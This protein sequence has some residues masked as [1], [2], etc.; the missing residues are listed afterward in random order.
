VQSIW[1]WI[2]SLEFGGISGPPAFGLLLVGIVIVAALVVAF[3]IFGLPRLNRRSTVTGVLFGE[4][5]D[6]DAAAMR[7]AADAAASA[8]DYPVAI[9][10]M[11]R[12]IAKAMVERTIV[13]TMPGTTAQEFALRAG[14]AFPAFADLLH[15]AAVAFDDVRYLSGAGSAE[16]FDRISVLERELRTARPALEPALA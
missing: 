15:E 3:L 4:N 9:A 13:T 2:N 14:V 1:D 5:D 16:Q 8:G 10:E 7:K 12:A 6:R 11:F